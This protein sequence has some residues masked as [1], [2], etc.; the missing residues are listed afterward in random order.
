MSRPRFREYP[1]GRK[2]PPPEHGLKVRKTGATWWGKRWIAALE[3]VLGGQAGRL[4]RGRSYARAGRVHDLVITE[5]RVDARVTGTAAAPYRVTL[6]LEELSDQVWSRAIAGLAQKAQFAAELLAGEM[7]EAIDELFR[8]AGGSLFPAERAQLTTH[9]SCPDPGDPC[10]HVAATHYVLGE[11]LDGDPFLLFELR[12]RTRD[13]ALE[14]LRRARVPP[15]ER[16]DAVNVAEATVAPATG[17]NL[18]TITP[19]DYDR[20]REPLPAL[21]FSFDEPTAPGSILRQLGAPPGWDAS[22]S[23]A[24]T[25]APL[26]RRAADA[27]RDVGCGRKRRRQRNSRWR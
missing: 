19:A 6:A 11:A 17:V 24:E 14:A 18:G 16:S 27:A 15:G 21:H 10:K 13:E 25:L 2:K 26:V 3:D 9:C 8:A 20:A 5:G 1:S 12:G 22:L 4:A 23:P 7:P